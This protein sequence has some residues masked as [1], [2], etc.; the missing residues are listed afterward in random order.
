MDAFALQPSSLFSGS[1]LKRSLT[2]Q[3]RTGQPAPRV[4]SRP[5]SSPT[6][7]SRWFAAFAREHEAALLATALRLCGNATD[8]R[9]LVQGTLERAWRNLARYKVGTDGR[10]WL[11]TI[12]H[13]LFIDLCRS[14]TRERRADVSAE[15]VEERIAAPEVEAAPAWASISLEQLRDALEKIPEDFRTVYQL[16]AMEGRSYVEIAERLGIPKATVGTR[17]I[18]A[19]RKL[20]EL[21]MPTP[22]GEGEG[23]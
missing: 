20:K 11:L 19:R 16:H 17:L 15:D 21:L 8:A 13:H 14:R 1:L 12:L 5:P 2:G 9:D 6:L 10:A 23:T 4:E 7:D 22:P 18:R 3:E